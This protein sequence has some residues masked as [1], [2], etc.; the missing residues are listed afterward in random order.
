MPPPSRPLGPARLPPRALPLRTVAAAPASA[1]SRPA[2]TRPVHGAALSPSPPRRARL[3]PL[4]RAR[5]P[6]P[7]VLDRRPWRA[8]SA[9]LPLPVAR[10]PAPAWPRLGAARP[11]S[12]GRG[13]VPR[14]GARG[15]DP[16]P[17]QPRLA[18]PGSPALRARPLP[19][20]Q[21]AATRR[22]TPGVLVPAS[23]CSVPPLSRRGLELG[24]ARAP[25]R[26]AP[27]W[28]RC[29]SWRATH[30]SAPTCAWLVRVTLAWLCAR[31]AHGALA[32]RA[33]LPLDVL[34]YPP[35]SCILC[36]LSTLFISINGNSI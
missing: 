16:L 31:G 22:G 35:P 12:P 5:L 3:P 30:S 4:W 6:R 34:V 15:P 36:A 32:R 13:A 10:F 7:D 9:S 24:P 26:L 14:P 29:R 18:G 25:P 11:R 17:T 2:R 20:Q 23:A 28:P 33:R 27:A 21:P 8:R 19:A 1:R